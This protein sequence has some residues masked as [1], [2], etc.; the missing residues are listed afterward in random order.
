VAVHCPL[1]TVYCPLVAAEGR[2]GKP[3][4]D[5]GRRLLLL[6]RDGLDGHDDVGLDLVDGA[7]EGAGDAVAPLALVPQVAAVGDQH[8]GVAAHF[9]GGP[10]GRLA[11]HDELDAALAEG[12]RVSRNRSS[13]KA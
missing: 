8:R 4:A 9:H 5:G 3:R 11:A 1:S 13:M 10:C 12:G 7:G 6:A 2:D